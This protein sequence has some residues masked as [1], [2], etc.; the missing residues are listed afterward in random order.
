MTAVLLC[1]SKGNIK[2]SPEH[3]SVIEANTSSE[4]GTSSE[5]GISLSFQR[6]NVNIITQGIALS[7]AIFLFVLFLAV[8]LLLLKV[9]TLEAN[10]FARLNRGTTGELKLLLLLQQMFM[11]SSSSSVCSVVPSVQEVTVK[12]L[13]WP[14]G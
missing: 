1:H 6:W 2:K 5:E 12:L 9:R 4:A 8:F 7:C 11:S 3:N 13:V 10:R 14:T